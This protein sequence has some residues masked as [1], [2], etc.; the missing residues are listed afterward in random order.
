MNLLMTL[1][2]Q[3]YK[4]A[5]Q[6]LKCEVAAIMAVDSV[7]SNGGGMLDGKP[8][9]LFEPHIFWKEL[10]RVGINPANH[11]ATH[12][13]ML[14]PVWGTKAY[15]KGQAAQQARLARAV[16]I[17]REAALRSCSWGRFQICGFNWS[18]TG[19]QSLQDF[20]NRMYQGDDEHLE[21]FVTYIDKA[22]LE[23]E[24]Q[25]LDWKGFARGYNG[26]LYARNRYDTKLFI[27]YKKF[28]AQG[29]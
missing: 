18:A 22:N 28:K 20:I 5:A 7:E 23:D 3:H 15:P 4:T 16:A 9:I 6:R 17:N 19:S 26:P 29:Y 21:M 11:I 24:L 1:S 10:K 27:A 2:I 8:I 12:S 14:Y 25:N 13:D